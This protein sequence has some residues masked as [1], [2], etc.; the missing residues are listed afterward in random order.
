MCSR[1]FDVEWPDL[2]SFCDHQYREGI[3]QHHFYRFVSCFVGEG[4]QRNRASRLGKGEGLVPDRSL[5]RRRT[6]AGDC[7]AE[8]VKFNGELVM[9]GRPDVVIPVIDAEANEV[10]YAS[11]LITLSTGKVAGLSD[12][13]SVKGS[14]E[15]AMFESTLNISRELCTSC[16][17]QTFGCRERNLLSQ[18]TS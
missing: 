15:G 6:H 4:A 9:S 16:S 5:R 17:M 8:D 3:L 12:R 18:R 2:H 10:G 13:R 1:R 14:K 11:V 7:R